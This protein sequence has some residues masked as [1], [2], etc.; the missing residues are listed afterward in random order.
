[1]LTFADVRSSHSSESYAG[2]ASISGIEGCVWI[3]RLRLDG[4]APVNGYVSMR[5]QRPNVES[6]N[7]IGGSDLGSLRLNVEPDKVVFVFA[8]DLHEVSSRMRFARLFDIL[9]VVDFNEVFAVSV[10]DPSFRIQTIYNSS[11]GYKT[12]SVAFIVLLL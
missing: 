2:K 6:I 12:L 9:M 1:M 8:V 5:N 11:N 3:S 7:R 10:L 4:C